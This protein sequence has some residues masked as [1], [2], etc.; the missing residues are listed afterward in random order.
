ME[1]RLRRD[2][3]NKRIFPAIDVLTSGTR[4]EDLLL[5][6]GDSAAT[7]TLRQVLAELSPQ[8]AVELLLD[9]ARDT[10]SNAEFLQQIKRSAQPPAS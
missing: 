1:L 9:K 4:R 7:A 3:A 2:L 6:P 5:A 8:Q 10:T